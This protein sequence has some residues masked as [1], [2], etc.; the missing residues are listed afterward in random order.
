MGRRSKR[1]RKPESDA[2]VSE[3]TTAFA[4][5]LSA[6][7]SQNP[8]SHRPLLTKCLNKL[9]RSFHNPLL[10]LLPTLLTRTSA[11][12]ASRA[13]DMV[14]SAA[15]ESLDMNR[16]I[17]SDADIIHA[18]LSRSSV[19]A[20]NALLDLCTTC[21]GRRRLIEFSALPTILFRFL[22]VRKYSTI[23]VTVCS[24]SGDSKDVN[25]VSVGFKMDEVSVLILNAAIILINTCDIEQ[26]E[27]IPRHLS[28]SFFAFM[29]NLWAN[30]RNAMSLA[31]PLDS[32]LG[33]DLHISNIRVGHVAE[34]LFR[35]SI[36]AARLVTPLPFR[37]VERGV[38]GFTELGFRGFMSNHWEVSPFLVRRPSAGVKIEEDDFFGPLSVNLVG[39]YP[40]FLSSILPGM[41][42]CLPIS[43]DELNILAF[44]EEARSKLGCPLIYQQDIRVVKTKSK[45]EVH[46]FVDSLAS[47]C[48]KDPHCLSAEDV[49]KCEEA[50]KDGYTVALR[51]MEFRFDSVAAIAEGLASVFG[52]PSLGANMYLTPPNSQG[53]A[54]HYDDHCVFVCQLVGTKKWRV[55]SQS[56]VQ[57][58]RLYDPLDRLHGSEVQNSMGDCKQY[59]LR[60]G[61]ILYIPRGVLHEACTENVSLDGSASCSLHITLGIEVEPPFEWEGFVHV[62]FFSWYQKQKQVNNSFESLSGTIHDIS[63]NLFHVAVGLIGDSDPT[64]RKACLV[65]SI[66]S[67]SHTNNWLDL[68]QRIIFCQLIDKISTQTRFL[69]VFRSI[70]LAVQENKDS[71]R[72]IKWLGFLNLD[73][74]SSLNDDQNM[75]FMGMKNLLSLCIQ[76]KDN[77]EAAFQQLKSRFCENVIFEDAI[78]SYK[79]LLDKYRNVRKQYMNGMVSLHHQL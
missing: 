26:L 4:V 6:L 24:A 7:S 72:R 29:R 41:V 16:T 17:A 58:P 30:V 2:A 40:S 8:D 43:S 25:S 78:V 20:C 69:E 27:Q 42:S 61:D 51:G 46:F 68:N 74:E 62:A 55:S 22:R 59:L 15:L 18:L 11:S 23:S 33:G 36:C 64:F 56:N 70:E 35:L 53:L 57:L 77:V 37:V 63:V 47:C 79:L 3:D 34:S 52:Q 14:G 73:K 1:K 67:S 32:T 31:S 49:S 9:R 39:A 60:E 71:L 66:F 45:K 38:F 10:S 76:H 28:Q 12:L 48:I 13:A 44:L 65:A 54:C 19:S 75:P 5:L 50:Y 21:V